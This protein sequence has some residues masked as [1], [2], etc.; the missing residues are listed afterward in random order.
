M[1]FAVWVGAGVF[2]M[3]KQLMSP[4]LPLVE[5]DRVV[6]LRT[7]DASKNAE[8]PRNEIAGPAW[9]HADWYV[10]VGEGPYDLHHSSVATEGEDSVVV[11]PALVGHFGSVTGPLGEHDVTRDSPMCERRLGLCLTAH[12]SSRSG[13]D[14]EQDALS[15]N[16]HVR[17][18]SNPSWDG[19]GAQ[20]RPDTTPVVHRSAL[21]DGS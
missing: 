1:A 21:V 7:W 14:D 6:G 9:Q 11:T 15:Q 20:P 17:K 2:E 16:R 4:T 10:T 13:I 12:A 5:G 8:D 18:I 3:A 19:V